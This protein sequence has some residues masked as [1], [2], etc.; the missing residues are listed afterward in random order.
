MSCLIFAFAFGLFGIAFIP[1]ARAETSN[2][3]SAMSAHEVRASHKTLAS[4]TSQPTAEKIPPC[5][6]ALPKA[7]S[8]DPR[9]GLLCIFLLSTFVVLRSARRSRRW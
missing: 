4:A 5:P 1:A 6:P 3:K 7:D 9:L 2:Q 8:L